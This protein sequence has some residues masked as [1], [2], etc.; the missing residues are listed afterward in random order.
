MAIKDGKNVCEFFPPFQ[1]IAAGAHDVVTV[2][3]RSF[4]IFENGTKLI[5]G[6]RR[7]GE[8]RLLDPSE[9]KTNIQAPPS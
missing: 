5:R 6:P 8:I 9:D 1:H 3:V 2:A 7:I 4:G